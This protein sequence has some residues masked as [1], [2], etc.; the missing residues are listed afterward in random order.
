MAAS[1]IPSAAKLPFSSTGSALYTSY[2]TRYTGCP[3]YYTSYPTHSM[4][5]PKHFPRRNSSI[6]SGD[7]THRVAASPRKHPL[8]LSGSADGTCDRPARHYARRRDDVP[9]NIRRRTLGCRLHG[10]PSYRLDGEASLPVGCR[11][12]AGRQRKVKRW[13]GKY[14]LKFPDGSIKGGRVEW[15]DNK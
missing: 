15:G 12:L 6:Q 7:T 14:Y 4:S 11:R 13:P 10:Q 2:P 1:L 8:I 5:Y 3:T 9:R